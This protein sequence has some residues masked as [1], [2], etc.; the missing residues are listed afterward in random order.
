MKQ[1]KFLYSY[2]LMFKKEQ[3]RRWTDFMK[4]WKKSRKEQTMKGYFSFS[5]NIYANFESDTENWG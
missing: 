2:W 5:S 1:Q 4:Q 3:R